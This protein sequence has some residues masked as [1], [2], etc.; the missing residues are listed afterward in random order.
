[1]GEP[2]SVTRE[3]AASPERVYALI[4]DLRRMGEWSPENEGGAWL[5]GSSAARPGAR[6][7]GRNRH[8]RYS[9]RTLATVIDADPARRFSFRVTAGPVKISDWSYTFETV[10]TGCRVTESWLDL[11]PRWFRPIGNLRTGVGDR[12]THNRQGMEQ[13]LDRLGAAAESDAL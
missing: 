13:T 9:W 2:V 12:P 6:F 7:R 1:M 11:R 5:G 8:G 3:M 10:P 4:T